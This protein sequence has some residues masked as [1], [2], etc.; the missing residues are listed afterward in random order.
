MDTGTDEQR[1][2]RLYR[3]HYA[4][5][6]AYVRRRISPDQ[7][8]DVVSEVFLVAWRRFETM[9]GNA[10][11]PWLY[12]VARHTLSSTY[13]SDERRLGLVRA[14]AA[15]PRQTVGDHADSVVESAALAAAFDSLSETDQE[16]LRLTA[17]EGLSAT[18]AAKA[19]ECTVASF[20]V[21]L[22]RARKRLRLNLEA[23]SADVSSRFSVLHRDAAVRNG[24]RGDA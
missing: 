22:H 1:F 11:L 16:A 20:H 18:Q 6:A 2:T 3:Q 12:G 19:L 7:V 8:V 15:Q 4:A 5:V 24:S 9:P 13:R 17:W 23:A 14:L 21:R 10:E